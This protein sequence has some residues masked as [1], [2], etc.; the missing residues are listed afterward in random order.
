MAVF[1]QTQ[2]QMEPQQRHV[3]Y[4]LPSLSQLLDYRV[5][6]NQ[7]QQNESLVIYVGKENMLK[8]SDFNGFEV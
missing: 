4:A 6:E 2:V 8:V 7:W 1:L 5:E 3:P